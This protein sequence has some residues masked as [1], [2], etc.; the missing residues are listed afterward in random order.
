MTGW[1]P[2][3][4]RVLFVSNRE[5]AN[6]RSGQ[7]YEVSLDGGY[8][9]KVMKAVGVEGAWSSDGKRLAYRPYI[10]AYTGSSGWRQHRGGDT[11]PIWIIDPAAK[12]LEK[13]PHVNAS[14]FNPIWVG[15]D[16]AFI[17]DR[18]EGSAN[19]F[20]YDSATREVRQLTHESPW[21]VRSAAAYGDTLVYEVGGRLKSLDLGTG[22]GRS[23]PIRLSVQ[24]NQARPRWK[25]A[26]KN[27]TSAWLSPTGKRVLITARGDVFSVPVKDGSVRNLTAT[28]GVREADA[29]WS[30]DGQRVAYLS[31]EGGAQALFIRDAVG[32][33]KPIRHSLGTMGYFKLL[34]WSPDDRR[35][36]FQ[37]NH[38]RLYAIDL[39][40][41]AVALI[42]TSPRR[43]EFNPAF[44][45]DGQWVAYTIEDANY[46]TRVRLHRLSGR[47]VRR[48]GRSLHPDR[49]P[50]VRG[51]GAALLHGVD[52]R[53]PEPREP[54]HVDS[55]TP[56]AQGHFCGHTRRR[57]QVAARAENGRRGAQERQ[58]QG[59]QGQRQGQG[60]RSQRK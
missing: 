59:R 26:G 30:K 52:R 3:G 1:S 53:R 34:G 40:S 17:S 22:Q 27:I 31:D 15:G 50:G 42:D 54:G 21:D 25:D 16:I 5:V 55:G 24:S 19:L 36:V 47:T 58:R 49:Q 60:G 23:I 28:S 45:P 56:A 44:S 51:R 18:N 13:I 32:L 43:D 10:M 37:D 2:D 6:S 33:E 11:P 7:F 9:R 12:T 8:V 57:R 14:D 29:L 48:P 35:I 4:K 46:F 38:L 41:E 39:Q 20:L